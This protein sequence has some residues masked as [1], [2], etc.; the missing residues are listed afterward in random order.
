[1]DKTGLICVPGN[2][3]GSLGDRYVRFALVL[4]EDKME[5]LVSAVDQSNLF[6]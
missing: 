1:M 2:S 3:F 5:E 4:P 6:K